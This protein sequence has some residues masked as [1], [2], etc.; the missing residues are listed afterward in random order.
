MDL[1]GIIISDKYQIIRE[2]ERGSMST[3][4]LGRDTS[5]N[6]D[7]AIKILNS[8][9]TSN[10]VEDVL[11]F[12]S[13]ASTISRI[14][15]PN[16]VKIF[17]V[18]NI[19]LMY[20]PSVHYI[21]MEY[22]NGQTLQSMIN[23]EQIPVN[24]ALEITE[25]ICSALE[26][27]HNLGIIHRDLK[28]SNIMIDST[29]TVKLIDF[30]L[31]RIRELSEL[32]TID[33][34]IGTFAYMPPAQSGIVERNIDERSDLYS[35]GIILYQ[36]LTGVLPYT[37][38]SIISII[39][40]HIAMVPT[41][42][43]QINTLIPDIIEDIIFKLIEKEPEKR[44]QT[45]R[46]LLCDLERYRYGKSDFILGL[47]DKTIQMNYR[48]RLIGRNDEI[49]YMEK[50]YMNMLSAMGSFCLIS[51]EAGIGKTRLSQELEDRPGFPA[52]CFIS[53]KAYSGENKTPYGPLQEA[54]DFHVRLFG[55][56]SKEKKLKIQTYMHQK[57]NDC[58]SI[59]FNFNPSTRQL[60]GDCPPPVG[61]DA[62]GEN[63]RFRRAL[64]KYFLH[65]SSAEDGMVLVINDM[66][67]LDEGSFEILTE[68]ISSIEKY[69][70]L[71]IG[72]YRNNEISETH[73]L[74]KIIR[75]SYEHHYP[76]HSI[77]LHRLSMHE[78]N[79][80]IS[81]LLHEE[82]DCLRNI[83]SLVFRKSSGN[84]FFCIEILKQ[85]IDEKAISFEGGNWLVNRDIISNI[86][87]S[88]SLLDLILRRLSL[89]TPY[90]KKLLAYAAVIGRKFDPA[91]LFRLEQTP[92]TASITDTPEKQEI[93]AVINKAISLNLLERDMHENRLLY[94]THDR[95][96]EAFYL[97]IPVEK[98]KILHYMIACMLEEM[99]TCSGRNV[100]DIANHF[101]E[102]GDTAKTLE[103]AYPAGL[104]ARENYANDNALSYFDITINLLEGMNLLSSSEY[105][106]L[107]LR[108]MQ[109]RGDVY[110]TI[111]KYNEAIKLFNEIMPHMNTDI[112]KALL[113]KQICKAYLKKGDWVNTE[114]YG[115]YGL[116][117]LGE[118]LPLSRFEINTSIAVEFCK[119]ALI[120]IL[121]FD[122]S[123]RKRARIGDNFSHII[124]LYLA[125][126]WSY[127]LNN[128]RK[129]MNVGLRFY[130][131]LY[132]KNKNTI[133][134]AICM[135]GFGM[136]LNV[137]HR[138][139]QAE[140]QHLM[141]LALST[142][143]NDEWGVAQAH[144]QLGFCYQWSGSFIR[145]LESFRKSAE[146]FR[147]IGDMRE[148][149]ISTLGLFEN[150]YFIADYQ[151]LISELES[152]HEAAVRS[153]DNYA[154]SSALHYR[155]LYYLETGDLDQCEN[156]A[157]K[158]NNFSYVEGIRYRYYLSM[159]EL[160]RLFI[161]KGE[162][163]RA[164]K[165]LIDALKLRHENNFIGHYIIQHDIYLAEV[166]INRYM[167]KDLN[168]AEK[169]KMIRI[170]RQ[171][172][173]SSL[174]GTKKWITHRGAALRA[175]ARY[176]ALINK[177]ERADKF[178]HMGITHCESTGRRYELAKCY[179]EYAVFLK[180]SRD[181]DRAIPFLEKAYSIFH[182]IGAV[183]MSEK[184]EN[185]LSINT[186]SPDSI[187]RL[188]AREISTSF[189]ETWRE[190]VTDTSLDNALSTILSRAIGFTGAQRG[191][192]FIYN[193]QTSE[194]DLRIALN[195][196]G[197]VSDEYSSNI[198]QKVFDTGELVITTNAES[199]SN[200]SEFN[201][202]SNYSLKSIIC[203]P[204]RF[205]DKITGV[206]YI[207]NP[208]ARNIF[209]NKDV[210]LFQTFIT[211]AS[212]IIQDR[213]NETPL[214]P[215]ITKNED[216][217]F[218]DATIEKLEQ[219]KEYLLRNYSSNISREALAYSVDMSPNY[220]SKLFKKY[221]GRKISRF[222]NELRIE[223]AARKL[224]ETDM[225][226]IDIAYSVGFESLRTFN[227]AFLTIMGDTPVNYRK[228]SA[229]VKF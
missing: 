137:L 29:G 31:A 57:L 63:R 14:E 98:R 93:N 10:R 228:S 80:L 48:T 177:K 187:Q 44:Y 217:A 22:I 53:S 110:L 181:P 186:S 173:K 25:Q 49:L 64:V 124:S 158:N 213:F 209:T 161:E 74:R 194:L 120:K 214:I 86:E 8:E 2:I 198:V 113:Y 84:P 40:Q 190:I 18:G 167:E 125:V 88:G 83:P 201:S 169:E 97:D 89:L 204:I 165:Y 212:L 36:M 75:L 176:Y 170:I 156:T 195:T 171:Y 33:E 131:L 227:R 182:R 20:M 21:V 58:G 199:E 100:F 133:E 39:H 26:H 146:L 180:N 153:G 61:I 55:K 222:I 149:A 54:I 221:T 11:R 191:Y 225:N 223:D 160:G 68:L 35:L 85:L 192:I 91:L 224:R 101:I 43:A 69:P 108:A 168:P 9:N 7:V 45:S 59:L 65:L 96:R 188:L 90:E 219:I 144:Q 205:H 32:K 183:R 216:I 154:I 200:Y 13:E 129:F 128:T 178:F 87:I 174:R 141:R 210:E 70:L 28:P 159:V 220:I 1:S 42:P 73:S 34:I 103:Y 164:Y 148:H 41:P 184:I 111:G 112:E 107:W 118:N 66:Q 229:T 77:H 202:V 38:D 203:M 218:T 23:H 136:L 122:M 15:H 71:V 166:C 104:K 126:A 60:I 134:D 147:K 157:F 189:M 130:N 12:H 67:W 155:M 143:I 81:A 3:V 196:S 37:G 5:N 114:K 132:R 51:G 27:I 121:P 116:R 142:R 119:F 139:E 208:L 162:T 106:D 95:I 152:Y 79:S 30:G 145:S 172:V 175:C 117:L 140:K 82:S 47:N 94:F 138:F 127:G 193:Y 78:I 226:I 206:C 17:D 109:A 50:L 56:Y 163:E 62:E 99:Y 115:F 72:T 207:D 135:G 150:Y 6:C 4:Y 19:L 211:Q 151:N 123:S 185:L 52:C 105:H 215:P 197:T 24:T 92:D 179:Y 76:L 16:I 46:G 102:S